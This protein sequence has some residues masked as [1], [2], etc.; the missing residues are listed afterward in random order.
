V[1]ADL[2]RVNEGDEWSLRDKDSGRTS[3]CSLREVSAG[4]NAG[5]DADRGGDDIRENGLLAFDLPLA[6][7]SCGELAIGP[8]DGE[9]LTEAVTSS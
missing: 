9:A 2:S 4:E 3:C 1:A 6:P 5:A 7:F 8:T